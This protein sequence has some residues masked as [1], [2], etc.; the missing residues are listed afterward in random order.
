LAKSNGTSLT[1]FTLPTANCQQLHQAD[2]RSLTFVRG[3]VCR[4]ALQRSN[5]SAT[6]SLQREP[7]LFPLTVFFAPASPWRSVQHPQQP[8][9]QSPRPQRDTKHR[10]SPDL[11]LSNHPHTLHHYIHHNPR[12]NPLRP[13]PLTQTHTTLT[14]H[15]SARYTRPTAAS[16]A[17]STTNMTTMVRAHSPPSTRLYLL[18]HSARGQH[19]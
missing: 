3:F 8:P 13:S 7:P 1:S 14:E 12:P 5:F 2:R 4:A 15:A 17:R 18:P 16:S 19:H 9:P 6:P 11:P 10:L